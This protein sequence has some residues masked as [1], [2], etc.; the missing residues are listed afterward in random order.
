MCCWRQWGS[1]G[2]LLLLLHL[3][4]M[5]ASSSSG[6]SPPRK[7]LGKGNSTAF[8]D[9]GVQLRVHSSEQEAKARD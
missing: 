4:M 5:S 3:L 1:V 9:V 8:V 6:K 2:L 7:V